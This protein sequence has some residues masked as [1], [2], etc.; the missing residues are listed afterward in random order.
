MSL[1]DEY[2]DTIRDLRSELDEQRQRTDALF[3]ALL[4]IVEDGELNGTRQSQLRNLRKIAKSAIKQH[5]SSIRLG[6]EL[7]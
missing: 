4:R 2:S 3:G 7:P 6:A 1:L 5:R